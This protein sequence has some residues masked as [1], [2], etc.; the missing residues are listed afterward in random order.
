MGSHDDKMY[1]WQDV[2]RK[3]IYFSDLYISKH[4]KNTRKIL[5]NRLAANIN[6]AYFKTV[7]AI[8]SHE[9]LKLNTVKK[10]LRRQN[11]YVQ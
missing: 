2:I 7:E 11:S 4:E 6:H 1:S 10:R 5:I 3:A 8:Q 9:M